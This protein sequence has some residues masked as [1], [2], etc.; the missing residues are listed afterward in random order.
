MRKTGCCIFWQMDS[1]KENPYFTHLYEIGFDGKNLTSLTPEEGNHS[2]TFSPSENYFIDSYSQPDVP[3][4][5]VLRNISGKI[6]F[7]LRQR[8]MFP[9]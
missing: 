7:N 1:I 4:V 3:A 9:G 8:Q 6:D 2:I 5:I